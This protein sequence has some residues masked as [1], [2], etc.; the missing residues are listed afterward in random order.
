MVSVAGAMN[1]GRDVTDN[2]DSGGLYTLINIVS[3]TFMASHY[4]LEPG[5]HWL[6]VVQFI[7]S[8]TKVARPCF[9]LRME[10]ARMNPGSFTPSATAL[11]VSCRRT[12][13]NLFMKASCWMISNLAVVRP[14]ILS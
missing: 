4:M 6:M 13:A 1:S 12:T 10:P 3:W 5:G 14:S 8:I 11:C 7:C 2:M 9:L